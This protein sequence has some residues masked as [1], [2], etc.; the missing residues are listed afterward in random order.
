[1]TE[2]ELQEVLRSRTATERRVYERLKCNGK[3]TDMQLRGLLN[4]SGSGPRDALKKMLTAGL[5]RHA[6]RASTKGQPM[7][8]EVTPAS[9]IEET[10]ERVAVQKSKRTRGRSSPGTR[11]AELRVSMEQGDCRKWYPARD[12]ILASLPL[13]KDTVKMAFW[14]SVPVQELEL[15]LGEIEELHDAAG[16]ALAAGRLRLEHEKNKAKIEKLART[17]GRTPAEKAVA[18]RKAEGLRRRLIET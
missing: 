11:L 17:E 15:A 10:R 12:Q 1:M 16:E 4:S 8:Y 5:V 6:G 14:E 13:L 18:A 9:E 3:L 7:Q 2:D